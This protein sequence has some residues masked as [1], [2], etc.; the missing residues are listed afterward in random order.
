MLYDTDRANG[1]ATALAFAKFEEQCLGMDY[2]PLFDHIDLL[3]QQNCSVNVTGI[4][5]S[6]THLHIDLQEVNCKK[7]MITK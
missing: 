4:V 7:P 5:S 6:T 3:Q 1:P 2:K